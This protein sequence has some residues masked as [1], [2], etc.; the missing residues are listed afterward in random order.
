MLSPFL[1]RQALLFA[2][3]TMISIPGRLSV[4]DLP[5]TPQASPTSD[6]RLLLREEQTPPFRGPS[7]LKVQQLNK[8]N[9]QTFSLLPGHL[10][11][12]GMYLMVQLQSKQVKKSLSITNTTNANYTKVL[13]IISERFYVFVHWFMAAW[14]GSKICL[15]SSY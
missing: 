3:H 11:F 10:L 4:P 13:N 6:Q 9:G 14:T 1:P 8:E 5:S 7:E 15:G 2:F 12:N